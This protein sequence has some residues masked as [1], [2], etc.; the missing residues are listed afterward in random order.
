MGGVQVPEAD[1]ALRHGYVECQGRRTAD[2]P[3][4]AAG[5]RNEGLKHE[6]GMPR[7]RADRK[8]GVGEADAKVRRLG[9]GRLGSGTKTIVFVLVRCGPGDQFRE[10]NAQ[11]RN[12]NVGS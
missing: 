11:L 3:Q 2:R 1:L 10:H 6:T 7:G 8:L 5:V 9:P 4:R 12:A